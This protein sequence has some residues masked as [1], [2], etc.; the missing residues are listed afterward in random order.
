[1]EGVIAHPDGVLTID[2]GYCRPGL[3]AIHL[4]IHQGEAAV[5]DSGTNA[6]VPRVLAALGAAGIAPERVRWVVL[7][8]VHLDHAGGAGSLMC[9][10]PQAQL[11]VHPRG[12]RHMI[13]PSRLWQ[14]TAEVYG[15]DHALALYGRLV[16]VPEERVVCPADGHVLDLA[17]RQFTVLHTPGHALHHICLYDQQA[18][19]C[20]TGDTFGLSFRELDIDGRAS[21]LPTTTPSQFDPEALHNSIDRLL[22]LQPQAMYLTHFGRVTDVARLAADLHRLIDAQVAVAQ[23]ARGEGAERHA[24]ILMGLRQIVHDESERQGWT[25]D[26]EQ[27][28]AL[29]ETDLELNAQ[30][31]AVWLDS[32]RQRDRAAA[33]MT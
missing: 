25:L 30:G 20:F 16:P 24:E 12:A 23:A 6:S 28:S 22:A 32:Q 29:L 11:V 4:V 21:V 13:D 5:I 18:R 31:L 3:A 15:A 19:A 17:G 7:T 10:L 33:V 26:S 2:S 27:L 1:M 14:A 8:H 9:A